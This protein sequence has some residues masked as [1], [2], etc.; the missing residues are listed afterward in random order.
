MTYWAG[1]KELEIRRRLGLRLLLLP[2]LLRRRLR[3]PVGIRCAAVAST[4]RAGE[5]ESKSA[6]LN[7]LKKCCKM[8]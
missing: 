2:L 1:R 6:P 7:S 8:L 5:E 4:L 3:R